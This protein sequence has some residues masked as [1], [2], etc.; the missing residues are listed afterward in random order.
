MSV[1]LKPCSRWFLPHH[2]CDF[3]SRMLTSRDLDDDRLSKGCCCVVLC[4]VVLYQVSNVQASDQQGCYRRL[5]AC[6]FRLLD[7]SL[8]LAE[9]GG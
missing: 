2:H 5:V 9:E 7:C 6:C 4:C 1:R 3:Y 8:A